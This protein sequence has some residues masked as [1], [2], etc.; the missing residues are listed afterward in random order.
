MVSHVKTEIIQNSFVYTQVIDHR[1]MLKFHLRKRTD[2]CHFL[3]EKEIVLTGC[4]D[5]NIV[6]QRRYLGELCDVQLTKKE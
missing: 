6:L 2:L 3:R 4:G 1:I 5:L